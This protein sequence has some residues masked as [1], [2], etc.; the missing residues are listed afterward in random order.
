MIIDIKPVQEE[1][2]SGVSSKEASTPSADIWIFTAWIQANHNIINHSSVQS[3]NPGETP[4]IIDHLKVAYLSNDSQGYW[5]GHD[6]C[7]ADDIL[8]HTQNLLMMLVYHISVWDN[9][10]MHELWLARSYQSQ[11][12]NP[13]FLC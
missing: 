9:P 7:T 5:I 6:A 4:L 12:D 3:D 1:G 13:R 8:E 2:A 11:E 10:M